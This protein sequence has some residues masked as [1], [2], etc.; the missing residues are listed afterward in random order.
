[1]HHKSF[2]A[3]ALCVLMLPVSAD[4][5][6]MDERDR[7]LKEI[8]DQAKVLPPTLENIKLMTELAD[9]VNLEYRAERVVEGTRAIG[10]VAKT[11]P[12]APFDCGTICES[13]VFG[14]PTT[15]TLTYHWSE[16]D[17]GT[18]GIFD[19]V[20]TPTEIFTVLYEFNLTDDDSWT[21]IGFSSDR[22]SDFSFSW[23][24][25]GFNPLVRA[26]PIDE[27]GNILKFSGPDDLTG[28]F[29]Q[30]VRLNLAFIP[31]PA[32]GLLAGTAFLGLASLG[33]KRRR[34]TR[35]TLSGAA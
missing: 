14:L 4:A 25:V 18:D 23:N 11:N 6:T 29:G 21:S 35:S 31:L 12:D 7:R 24:I 20:D 16:T 2:Y 32:S 17:A 5:I 22:S 28:N 13:Y 34:K 9:K 1:M 26:T 30:G 3:A 10:E 27:F 8:R 33:R 15:E 19:I